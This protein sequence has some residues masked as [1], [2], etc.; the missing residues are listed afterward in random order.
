MGGWNG[1][2]V[3]TTMVYVKIR[4]GDGFFKWWQPHVGKVVKGLHLK[5]GNQE[6][7]V[8]DGDGSGS[9]KVKAGG[10]PNMPHRSFENYDAWVPE[11]GELAHAIEECSEHRWSVEE[12][13]IFNTTTRYC[14][15]CRASEFLEDQLKKMRS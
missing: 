12:K 2:K 13:E 3:E 4:P 14:E 7:C 15:I 9:R 10:G 8:Y 6:W 11:E 1:Q 5:Q